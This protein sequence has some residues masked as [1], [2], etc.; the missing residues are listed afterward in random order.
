M[1][2]IASA[3]RGDFERVAELSFDCIMCGLCASRCLAQ[4]SPY[5][6]AL[7]A[8]RIYAKT[9]LI[10]PSY[11][12]ER[13]QEVKEGKYAPEIDE[14]MQMQLEDIQYIYATRDIEDI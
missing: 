10:K 12:G 11:I 6:I 3:Q 14:L 8:R 1:D 9:T 7:Y 5:H 2:Y 4:M 13:M